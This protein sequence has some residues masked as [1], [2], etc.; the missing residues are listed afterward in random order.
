MD[1]APGRSPLVV[2]SPKLGTPVA[3]VFTA[4]EALCTKQQRLKT[5]PLAKPGTYSKQTRSS[6]KAADAF[7]LSPWSKTPSISSEVTTTGPVLGLFTHQWPQVLSPTL[8][9]H[10]NRLKG[11]LFVCLI[12]QLMRSSVFKGTRSQLSSYCWRLI[13][14][15]FLQSKHEH[16]QSLHRCDEDPVSYRPLSPCRSPCCGFLPREAKFGV[17]TTRALWKEAGAGAGLPRQV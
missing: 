1:A 13:L 2:S 5:S 9:T 8:S 14:A 16:Q 3:S 15:N 12:Q 7:Q 6:H 10:F 4:A 17:P 11:F